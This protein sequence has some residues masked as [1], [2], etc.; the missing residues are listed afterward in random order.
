M[1]IALCGMGVYFLFVSTI[2]CTPLPTKEE[3]TGNALHSCIQLPKIETL[4]SIGLLLD[5]DS[6]AAK[7]KLTAVFRES[8]ELLSRPFMTPEFDFGDQSYF[9]ELGAYSEKTR[10]DKELSDLSTSRGDANALYLNR[11]YFGLYNL[12]GSLN[13]KISAKLPEFIAKPAA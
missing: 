6:P 5:T 2:I 1:L 9:D 12:M 10:L 7:A 3:T 13:A 11:T 8:V 4:F